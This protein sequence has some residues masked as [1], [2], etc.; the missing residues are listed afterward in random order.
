MRSYELMLDFYGMRMKNPETGE[1]ERSK[2][3]EA[4]YDNLNAS[5]H[6]CLRIT[7]IL[8]SLGELGFEHLKFNFLAFVADEIWRHGELNNCKATIK[9]YWTGTLRDN[10]QRAEMEK[11][12]RGFE[13]APS[14]NNRDRFSAWKAPVEIHSLPSWPCLEVVTS[15]STEKRRA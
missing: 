3:Y 10:T 13:R 12:I 14:K 11:M 5:G 9:N 7:R 1:L 15:S 6:N 4:R 8:K 2:N